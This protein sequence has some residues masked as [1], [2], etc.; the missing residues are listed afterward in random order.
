M[1]FILIEN[2]LKRNCKL[3]D[4]LII[5]KSEFF[6]KLFVGHYHEIYADYE[7]IIDGI[8]IQDINQGLLQNDYLI[9]AISAISEFPE[10]ITRLLLQQN[11]SPVH[12]YCVAIC[13]T[14]VFR[15]YQLDDK[16]YYKT[17]KRDIT[18]FE[19]FAF[20]SSSEH[21][22]WT[23]LVEK[24]YAK[25][26]GSYWSI[27]VGRSDEALFDLTGAPCERMNF[28]KTSILNGKK[29]KN[30]KFKKKEIKA[31]FSKILDY[32]EKDYIM[33]VH[34]KGRRGDGV[35]KGINKGHV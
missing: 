20:A 15:D 26:Y 30:E 23:S 9:S 33:T 32:D 1:E 21:E 12:A 14:G 25:S 27:S 16:F 13:R 24:A 6:E 10:R 35:E 11:K 3:F 8:D 17:D 19:R 29:R 4:R 28:H 5:G 18:K 31:L 2:T 22:L 7:P 34:S